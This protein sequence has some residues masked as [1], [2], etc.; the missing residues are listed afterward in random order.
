MHTETHPNL[1]SRPGITEAEDI[2]RSC[3]HCGFCTAVCPTYQQ[4]GDDLD[5]PRGRIYLIKTILEEDA[6]TDQMNQHLDRCLTCRSCETT[7]P[8][9]VKYGRL[10]DIGKDLIETRYEVKRPVLRELTAYGLRF[11]LPKPRLFK[12]LYSIGLWFRPVL[13][14]ALK[15]KMPL[16][17][18]PL[19]PRV[20]P[21]DATRTVLL[22]EG[23]VQR[24][25]TPGVNRAAETLLAKH[26]IAVN[27]L[28]DEGC[29][30]AVDYHLGHHGKGLQRMRDLID[31]LVERLDDVEW[32]ISTASGCGVT[33][34]EY[35]EVFAH[36][37]VYCEK[38]KKV[39]AKVRDISEVL[40]TLP[41][42]CK[43]MDV[44]VHTPCTLQHGQQLP[45]QV[46][47]ILSR[48]GASLVPVKESHLCCGS[49]GTYSVLQAELAEGLTSRKISNLLEH[50]PE[51]IVT[52]NVGCQT[53]LTSYAPTPV[54]HWVE[55][56]AHFDS[57]ETS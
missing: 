37:P 3:V 34:K 13:P 25:L 55:F 26:N 15:K 6:V 32:I 43:P 35:P 51:L 45:G 52:A 50:K 27:Y 36:D 53:Q 48:A 30:G 18:V 22:L 9:G 39:V 2:L 21:V 49:A 5:S 4:L 20:K 42:K 56:L 12:L 29:C 28:A 10:L 23:C 38:A 11:L 14:G 44:A 1:K 54:M 7:C 8:S 31:R 47:D 57:N 46:E 19:L 41:F 17:A 33:L 40:S 16:S 24:T